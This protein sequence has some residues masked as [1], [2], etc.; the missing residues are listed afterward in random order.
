MEHTDPNIANIANSVPFDDNCHLYHCCVCGNFT[1]DSI[2]SLNQHIQCDRTRTRE[3][4]VL[5]SIGGSYIC[6]LCS[7]K[8]NLKANFQL[9]CKTDKHLQRLQHVN[10]IK[11]GGSSGVNAE[12]LKLKL[13][14][15]SNPI[16]VIRCNVCNY[17]TNSIHKLQLHSA[18][19]R[20]DVYSR[21][22]NHLQI[23][24]FNISG[25]N[26]NKYFYCTLCSTATTTKIQL[27]QHLNSFKHIR[28][29]NLRQLKHQQQQQQQQSTNTNS[30]SLMK[31]SDEEIREMFLVKELRPD[32]KIIFDNNNG[33]LVMIY[34]F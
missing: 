22:F 29:E 17:Y 14:Q 15:M 2:D 18:N 31:D 16:Q 11:E 19:P 23:S 28:N 32:D 26:N 27:I 33:K 25:N 9:H 8:T 1:S 5:M 12:H 21:I 6:K 20:H 13:V 10:H 34:K 24:E 7:Y 4:E 3:D 30:T